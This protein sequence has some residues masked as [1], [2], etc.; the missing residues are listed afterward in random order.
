MVTRFATFTQIKR[1]A[2]GGVLSYE[3]LRVRYLALNFYAPFCAFYAPIS[4]SSATLGMNVKD[5]KN[6]YKPSTVVSVILRI[7]T[8]TLHPL[9][10][11]GG[12]VLNGRQKY[13]LH[14]FPL[15]RLINSW[16][17]CHSDLY[18]DSFLSFL[19]VGLSL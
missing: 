6:R 16:S 13:S 18:L 14:S 5:I 17:F 7:E 9:L 1:G 4:K 11:C 8:T 19:Q 2:L 15:P 3:I 10:G 12:P